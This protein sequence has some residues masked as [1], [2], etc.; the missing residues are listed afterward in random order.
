MEEGLISG[1]VEG[2]FFSSGTRRADS[3]LES[4]S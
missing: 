4:S 1:V 3:D 2:V